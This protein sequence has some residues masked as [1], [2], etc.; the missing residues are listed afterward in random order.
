MNRFESRL[1][2]LDASNAQLSKRARE[3]ER[4]F[5]AARTRA[6]RESCVGCAA[7]V[8]P[9]FDLGGCWPLWNQF[10]PDERRFACSRKW[11]TDPA[12][13]SLRGARQI[14]GHSPLACWQTC[15]TPMTGRGAAG[16]HERHCTAACPRDPPLPHVW[17]AAWDRSLATWRTSTTDG[18][19]F[20]QLEGLFES[21]A[22]GR[23]HARYRTDAIFRVF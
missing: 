10:A 19:S 11:T 7:D 16:G 2:S 3:Q 4:R 23:W 15:W 17:R 6:A 13:P 1:Q 9:E 18:R 21:E 22:R 5:G 12:Y 20:A 14:D 8:V